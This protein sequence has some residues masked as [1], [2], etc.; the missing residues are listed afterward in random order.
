[1]PLSDRSALS[2]LAGIVSIGIITV[3]GL[4]VR[5]QT[6]DRAAIDSLYLRARMTSDEATVRQ[7]VNKLHAAVAEAPDAVGLATRLGLL[8][9]ELEE[10][11][12]AEVAFHLALNLNPD[13]P[14]VH[15]GLGRVLLDFR[16]RPKESLEALQTAVALDSTFEEAHFGLARAYFKMGKMTSARQSAS[17]AITHNPDYALPYLLLAQIY[18][19]EENFRASEIYYQRYLDQNPDDQDSAY[20]FALELLERGQSAAFREIA[21]RLREVRALPLVALALLQRKDYEGALEKF[22]TFISALDPEE[23]SLYR[24]ISLVGTKREIRLYRRTPSEGMAAFLDRFWM[25][26]DPFKT[27]GGA[28]RRTEHYRRVWHARTRFGKKKWPW[29]KRGETYIRYGEPDYKTNSRQPNPNVPLDVQ[30][31]QEQLAHRLYGDPSIEANFVGPIFPVR[32]DRG[33]ARAPEAT[34]GLPGWRPVTTSDDWSAVPWEVWIYK[35]V[36]RGLEVVFTDEYHSDSYGYAPIPN[37]SPRDLAELEGQGLSP[38]SVIQRF[39]AAA[40]AVKMAALAGTEPEL[41]RPQVNFKGLDFYFDALSFR[42]KDDKTELQVVIGLPIKNVALTGDVDTTVVVQQRVVLLDRSWNEHHKTVRDILV[43]IS[44]RTRRGDNMA[45]DLVNLQT[46]PGH[47]EL[48]VQA[49]RRETDL[50][51]VYRMPIDLP[52]YSRDRLMLS[53]L[54]LSQRILEA[55]TGSDSTFVRGSWKILPAPSRVFYTHDPIFVYFE[56]YNLTR[57]DFG[58]TRYEVSYEVEARDVGGSIIPFLPK[59]KKKDGRAIEVTYEQTGTETSVFDY[60]EMD[61]DVAK[62]GRY[63]LRVGIKDLNNGLETTRDAQFKI[64]SR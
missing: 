55:R 54:Q 32:A 13:L 26:K 7:V 2:K 59:L 3:T 50:L 34:M 48:A 21:L 5:A 9:L 15:Y 42:G 16:D 44:D 28:A 18:R 37:L 11:D 30:R 49:F 62:P 38:L 14:A 33:A 23:A 57:D 29:D 31:V 52:D 22:E 10:P 19:K 47:Y 51:Q 60:V 25:S 46:R 63:T 53:D 61:L 40:P 58:S 8:Y 20:E 17:R 12:S 64:V 41:Y 6:L 39:G 43:P 1:M 35:D 27:Y 36:E 24:D 4:G 56:L 45:M